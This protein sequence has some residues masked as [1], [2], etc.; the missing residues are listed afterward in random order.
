[1]HGA[2]GVGLG[3][4]IWQGVVAAKSLRNDL[5]AYIIAMAIA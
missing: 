3:V 5:I 2:A 1:M 4:R